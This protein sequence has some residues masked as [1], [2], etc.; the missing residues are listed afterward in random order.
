MATLFIDPS[1]FTS[2]YSFPQTLQNI[3]A[4]KYGTLRTIYR[5][6]FVTL[7]LPT[8]SKLVLKV[9]VC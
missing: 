1:F 6:Y 9:Q 2:A 7:T 8:V 4:F 3:Q 5:I